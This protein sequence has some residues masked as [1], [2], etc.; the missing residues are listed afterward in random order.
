MDMGFISFT[1]GILMLANGAMA[2]AMVLA[3]RLVPMEAATWVNSSVASSMDL[4][5][6]ISGDFL[7]MLFFFILLLFFKFYFG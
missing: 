4:G 5:F 7:A 1:H 3:C 6:T 2:R